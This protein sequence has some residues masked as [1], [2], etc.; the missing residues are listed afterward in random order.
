MVRKARLYDYQKEYLEGMPKDVIMSADV[1]LGKGQMALAHY[2]KY[3]QGRPLLILAPASKVRTGDWDR[4]V[5]MAFDSRVMPD[6]EVLSYDMF[7][8]KSL[9]YVAKEVPKYCL[10][11]DESHYVANSQAKRS[12]AVA[13]FIKKKVHQF[14]GLSATPLPNGWSSLENYAILFGLVK[15]K[16]EFI[17]TYVR[18][19]RTRGFPLI[20]GYNFVPQL[21]AFWNKVSKPLKRDGIADLPKSTSLARHVALHPKKVS[22]YREIIKNKVTPEGEMLDSPSKMFAYL[23]QWTTEFRRDE[24]INLIEGTDEHIVVFYNYD[25]ERDLILDVLKKHFPDRTVYEQS[26]HASNLPARDTWDDMKPSVTLAQYQSASTAIELTYASVTIYLSPTYSF[27][28]FHQSMGRTRRNGQKK[29]TL[30]YMIAVIGTMDVDV[31]KVLKGK[32][33][34]D[35]KLFQIWLDNKAQEGVL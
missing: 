4:E 25:V 14:I 18:I 23:R 26:G 11:L 30:F 16:T 15:N 12:K 6:Y 33:N 10:I 20:L 3:S 17:N 19:D 9:N 1:G 35:E 21:E 29:K 2:K 31:Y 13:N 32:Q 5:Q 34:F 24:L 22:E 8:R 27:A 28:Q 7:A